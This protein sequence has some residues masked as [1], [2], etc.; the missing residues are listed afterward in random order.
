M[1]RKV[2]L[3]S[4]ISVDERLVSVAE[5]S[6]E[7]A[8]LWPWLLTALDDWGRCEA[9]PERLKARVW[10]HNRAVTVSRIAAALDLFA[11]AGL[12]EMY[13]VAG[14][15][16]IARLEHLNEQRRYA[17]RPSRYPDPIPVGPHASAIAAYIETC[18]TWRVRPNSPWLM[19]RR[20]VFHRD[21]YM[22]VYCG[23]TNREMLTVDHVILRAQGGSDDPSNLVAACWSCN[24]HKWARTPEQAGMTMRTGGDA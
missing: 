6:S 4:D 22:C 9:T 23:S 19:H 15:A 12:F 8:I 20:A 1:R 24:R 2:L 17:V 13:T 21:G 14:T 11:H 18:R 5:T 16:Y 3:P 10:P 7:A